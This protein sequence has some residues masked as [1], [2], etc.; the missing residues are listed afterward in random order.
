[1][2][3]GSAP[4]ASRQRPRGAALVAGV[5]LALVGVFFLA[6]GAFGLWKARVARDDRGFVT[7]GTTELRT[8]Q[9]ARSRATALAG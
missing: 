4:N 9:Y 3:V 7:F 1:V 5:L 2:T 6:G 8:G